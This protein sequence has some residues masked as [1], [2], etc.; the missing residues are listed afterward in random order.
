VGCEFQ[1][2]RLRERNPKSPPKACAPKPQSSI[3]SSILWPEP[4]AD[5]H[6]TGLLI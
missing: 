2:E 1:V 6:K 5:F 3:S 4:V